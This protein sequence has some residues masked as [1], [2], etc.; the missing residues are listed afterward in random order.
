MIKT[1]MRLR[2]D[3]RLF[4][5]YHHISKTN[6]LMKENTLIKTKHLNHQMILNY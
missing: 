6:T 1:M 4:V 5:W 2:S 3:V